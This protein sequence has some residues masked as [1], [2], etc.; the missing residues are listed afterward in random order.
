MRPLLSL[1]VLLA[2]SV[3]FT[4]AITETTELINTGPQSLGAGVATNLGTLTNG[5][6]DGER[7]ITLDLLVT[8]QEGSGGDTWFG[9]GAN[10]STGS[11]CHHSRCWIPDT[12]ANR[13][14]HRPP[15][16]RNPWH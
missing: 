10:S 7:V 15:S 9:I 16:I 13:L 11:G 6:L 8:R 12:H 4:H 1:I 14:R 2:C 5:D 3:S